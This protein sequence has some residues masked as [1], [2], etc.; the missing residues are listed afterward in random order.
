MHQLNSAE[1]ADVI[2]KVL[3]HDFEGAFRGLP[4]K[5]RSRIKS[6][7][8]AVSSVLDVPLEPKKKDDIAL[9]IV[10]DLEQG[11][12]EQGLLHLSQFIPVT[13][14]VV[15]KPPYLG[16]FL[17]PPA[18]TGSHN[19][20][21]DHIA[22]E[23]LSGT[24]PHFVKW[25]NDFNAKFQVA[26]T[27]PNQYFVKTSVDGHKH[28]AKDAKQRKMPLSPKQSDAYYYYQDAIADSLTAMNQMELQKQFPHFIEYVVIELLDALKTNPHLHIQ[29][30]FKSSHAEDLFRGSDFVLQSDDGDWFSVDVTTSID[31]LIAAE[32][33][34]RSFFRGA[35]ELPNVTHDLRLKGLIGKNETPQYP[36][37]ILR[38]HSRLIRA[39]AY[40]YL[41]KI[42]QG[43][44]AD[45]ATIFH[46][47][48]VRMG[49][50][51]DQELQKLAIAA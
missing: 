41:S 40:Q 22:Q 10:H 20:Q 38:L 2:S 25:L 6:T 4:T 8:D 26:S 48:V 24:N 36:Q 14:E 1:M 37:I 31:P 15:A 7:R 44:R 34:S 12:V 3:H 17:S 28:S 32:K 35:A 49:L 46:S 21:Y 50:D 11:N 5:M 51:M 47:T 23:I 33:R 29:H 42:G 19:S 43:G 18:P 16:A 9:R 30:I 45:I 39:F 27:V 13:P